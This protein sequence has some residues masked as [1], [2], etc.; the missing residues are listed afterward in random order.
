MRKLKIIQIVPELNSGGV[1][2]GTLELGKYLSKKGHESVVVS[3]GGVMIDQ[4]LSEGTRHIK[5]PVHRKSPKSLFQ[6]LK[7]RKL[8]KGEKPDIVHARSRVPAWLSFMALKLIPSSERA[9][10]VTTFHGFYSINSFSKIMTFGEKIICVSNS[11]HSYVKK[12]YPLVDEEKLTVI[13]RGIDYSLYPHGFTPAES[14]SKQWQKK[15]PQTQNK[16][17]IILPGRITRLKGHETFIKLIGLLPESFHGI[18]A[19]DT[20]HKKLSYYK[21]LEYNIRRNKL[22]DR[23]TFVG[24]RNDLREVFASSFV[25]L[26]ISEKPESF[27]RTVLESLALGC[28]VI[29]YNDGGVGEILR[30]CFPFGLTERGEINDIAR[31]II[32]LDNLGLKPSRISKFHLSEMLKMTEDLYMSLDK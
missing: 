21:G 5:I 1:E 6:V 17:L 9:K 26:S 24:K 15:F 23:I 7:L 18:V 27:G 22:E 25:C 13:H 20:H 28:P 30:E 10:F 3:N 2:R 11:V 12:S 31:K 29:G 19:G 8:F 32:E 16:K 14:W 4:L